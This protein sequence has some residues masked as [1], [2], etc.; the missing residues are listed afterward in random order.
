MIK[1]SRVLL[2]ANNKVNPYFSTRY[3]DSFVLKHFLGFISVSLAKPFPEVLIKRFFLVG[4][5]NRHIT[6]YHPN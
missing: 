5:T 3:V 6:S 2:I 4:K 1:K